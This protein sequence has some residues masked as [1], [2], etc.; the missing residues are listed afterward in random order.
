MGR[1]GSLRVAATGPTRGAVLELELMAFPRDRR[2]EWS[3]DG[4]R[5]GEMDVAAEWRRYDLPL[6]SLAPVEATLTLAC[7]EPAVVAGDVLGNGDPR[8]VGLAVRR[9][10]ITKSLK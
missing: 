3:V 9:W 5:R 10:W 2:V 7:R 8:T 4:D 6:G 1:T